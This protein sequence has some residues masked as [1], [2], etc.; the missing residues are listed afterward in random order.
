MPEPLVSNVSDTARWVAAYRA[1]ESERPDPL[2]RDPYARRLAGERGRAIADVA[3]SYLMNGWP[4]IVRTK[5]IDDLVGQ[6]VR[7]GADRVLNLAAGLDTRPYRLALPPSLTWI[8]ADLPA[9]IEEKERLLEGEKPACALTRE[10]VDLTDATVR[11]EFLAGATKGAEKALVITEG[12]LIYLDDE[13]ARGLSAALRER[14]EVAWWVCD[15][16]SPAIVEMMRKRM[17]GHLDN[18][19]VE[20][21]PSNGVAF[22]EA[23]G[24]RVLD[25]SSMLREAVHLRRLP[26]QLWVARFFPDPDPRRLGPKMRWSGVVRFAK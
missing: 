4:I 7:S 15:L 10:K 5:L 21:A 14:G 19:R 23:L 22:F 12:L 17:R 16:A 26:W 18:A 11:A 3:R 9:M 6:C 25:V 1:A 13:S 2:F 8:E 20:F 24:W